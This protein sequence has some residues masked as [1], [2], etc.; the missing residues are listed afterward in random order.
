MFPSC[1]G[2]PPFALRPSEQSGDVGIPKRMVNIAKMKI[3]K[4][5]VDDQMKVLNMVTH[6]YSTIHVCRLLKVIGENSM[7]PLVV[8]IEDSLFIRIPF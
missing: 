7:E 6:F 2:I 8:V 5:D 3:D 1:Q 4:M